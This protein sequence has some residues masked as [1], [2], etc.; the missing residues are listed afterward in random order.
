MIAASSSQLGRALRAAASA[1]SNCSVPA[2]RAH[3]RE[4]L[5]KL[6]LVVGP[7]AN[8]GIG[9]ADFR[10]HRLAVARLAEFEPDRPA[11]GK[12]DG[13]VGQVDEDLVEGAPVGA[14]HDVVGGDAEIE[15]QALALRRGAQRG[16][17]VLHELPARFVEEHV[18]G[19]D[20]GDPRLRRQVRQ[21]PEA[22][23]VVGP[24]A[25]RQGQI[26]AIAEGFPQVAQLQSAGLVRDIG[27]EDSDQALAI[28]D[29]IFNHPFIAVIGNR[30]LIDMGFS[31]SLIE[32]DFFFL[33]RIPAV[34][35][36]TAN[37]HQISFFWGKE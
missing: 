19:D 29:E 24:P 16:H 13:V 27:N 5:E 6:D 37:K 31:V 7:D 11:I 32:H 12:F 23:L 15:F 18:I 25:Q 10:L 21:F 20:G 1:P 9:D 22:H 3:L 8:A 34:S 26:G 33:W 2:A 17:H 35:M 14:D 36:T 4:G 30:N 28:G